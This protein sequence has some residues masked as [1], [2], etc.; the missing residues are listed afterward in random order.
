MNVR[1]SV[2][3]DSGSTEHDPSLRHPEPVTTDTPEAEAQAHATTHAIREAL[4]TLTS[5]QRE[6]IEAAFFEGYTHWELSARF[7]L[8]LGTVKT[9]I[10]AGL[11]A[12]RGRLEQ[13]V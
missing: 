2:V 7:G 11:S 10:R 5:G 3:R 8:P 13:V 6:L 9:R 4:A 1:E 12:M